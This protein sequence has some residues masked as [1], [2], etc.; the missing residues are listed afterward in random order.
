MMLSVK[1][2]LFLRSSNLLAAASLL[3]VTTNAHAE[4]NVLYSFGGADGDGI[5]PMSALTLSGSTLY[6]TTVAAPTGGYGNNGTVFKINT[7]GTGY[8]T[9]YQFMGWNN[10]DGSAPIRAMTLDSGTLYGTT[11][12]GGYPDKGTVFKINTGGYYEYNVLHG[13]GVG[14][15]R[16][17]MPYGALGKR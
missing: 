9:M 10:Y 4:F 7:D 3:I 12:Y 16:G 14:G 5:S 15:T 8:Q 11:S 1:N 6:G 17:N 2:I 13:F